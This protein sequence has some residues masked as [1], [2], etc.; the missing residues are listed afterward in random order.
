M[1]NVCWMRL[2]KRAGTWGYAP[3]K[4][5]QWKNLFRKLRLTLSKHFNPCNNRIPSSTRLYY[6]L[7]GKN[8]SI[9]AFQTKPCLKPFST[10][11][12]FGGAWVWPISLTTKGCDQ[13]ATPL[14]MMASHFKKV[15]LQTLL[16]LVFCTTWTQHGT[17]K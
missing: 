4:L 15:L 14:K 9:F 1:G 13:I 6:G 7:T 10:P 17:V 2:N 3:L 8:N 16:F 5:V 12:R 11:T